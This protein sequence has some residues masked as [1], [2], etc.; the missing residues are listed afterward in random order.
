MN[1]SG[2]RRDLFLHSSLREQILEHLFVGKALQTMW[3][4]GYRDMEVLRGE[5]DSSGFDVV[6]AS[7]RIIR[8]IQ[9]KSSHLEGRTIDQKVNLALATK[10]SGCIVWM[11]ICAQTLEPASYLWFG[12]NPG[13]PLPDINGFPAARHTKGNA[14]GLKKDRPNIRKISKRHFKELAS[15]REVIHAL[16]G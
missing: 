3:Q 8:H 10:P 14:E 12:G 1:L 13:E 9:L 16:F 11:R 4:L 15:M 6:M 7:G 5:I 2:D